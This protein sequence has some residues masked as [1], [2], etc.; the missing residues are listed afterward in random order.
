MSWRAGAARPLTAGR[1]AASD[2]G[3][4]PAAWQTGR[5][6]LPRN[7]ATGPARL[8]RSLLSAAAR[9]IRR[10]ALRAVDARGWPVTPAGQRMT[11][12]TGTAAPSSGRWSRRRHPAARAAAGGAHARI[13]LLAAPSDRRWRCASGHPFQAQARAAPG[14]R[15][16]DPA[17]VRMRYRSRTSDG[18]A[19]GRPDGDGCRGMAARARE[20]HAAGQA[21]PHVASCASRPSP[22]A[23][24]RSGRLRPLRHL[25]RPAEIDA[26]QPATR[27]APASSRRTAGASAPWSAGGA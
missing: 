20:L 4:G 17:G 18:I 12:P 10:G 5:R 15:R 25:H 11:R 23:H 13:A 7:S 16:G 2:C 6:R 19:P 22:S 14:R 24:G 8:R 27:R 9:G 3:R 1:E 21:T 26:Q